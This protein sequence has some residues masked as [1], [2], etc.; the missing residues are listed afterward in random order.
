MIYRGKKRKDTV[1]ICLSA[2]DVEPGKIAVN[3]GKSQPF[4]SFVFRSM[5]LHSPL[6]KDMY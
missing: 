5:N 6:K 2:D 1:L 4:P 3:K